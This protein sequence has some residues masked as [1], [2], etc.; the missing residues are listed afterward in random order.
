MDSSNKVQSRSKVYSWKNGHQTAFLNDL[1]GNECQQSLQKS[2]DLLTS[3]DTPDQR[4]IDDAV[5]CFNDA[6]Y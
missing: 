6:I 1:L 5:T 3:E 2:L 4:S